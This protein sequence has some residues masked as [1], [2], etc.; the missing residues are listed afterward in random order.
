MMDDSQGVD[1]PCI[2]RRVGLPCWSRIKGAQGAP[3]C[4]DSIERHEPAVCPDRANP[5]MR[6]DNDSNKGT[7]EHRGDFWCER[8]QSDLVGKAE[9]ARVGF[10]WMGMHKK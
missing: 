4:R 1:L 6:V 8:I 7:V 3:H 5:A 2:N 10:V 9:A